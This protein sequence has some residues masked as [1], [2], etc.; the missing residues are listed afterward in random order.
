MVLKE[1]AM[2]DK[3]VEVKE[4]R[5]PVTITLDRETKEKMIVEADRLGIS[6]SAFIQLLAS[7]YFDGIVFQRKPILLMRGSE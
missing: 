5:E 1:K 4:R 6:L 7:Q 3:H 2:E